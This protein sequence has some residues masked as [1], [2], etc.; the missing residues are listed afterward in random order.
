MRIKGRLR[1]T[2]RFRREARHDSARRRSASTR[3]TT[4]G[5]VLMLRA[6]VAER[7]AA[8]VKP[9]GGALSGG[10]AAPV[11]DPWAPVRP[12][13]ARRPARRRVR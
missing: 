11:G 2:A 9:N 13:A 3:R 12:C 6:R 4:T 1:D 10:L 8:R 7:R 5:F